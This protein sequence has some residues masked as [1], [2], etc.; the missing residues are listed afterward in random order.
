MKRATWLIACLSVSLLLSSCSNTTNVE[1]SQD[2]QSS[3]IG[4]VVQPTPTC[5]SKEFTDG[6]AWIEGQLK[7]FSE[8]TPD[9]AYSYASD[10]FRSKTSLEAFASVILSQYT[11][12][13][14]IKD[15]QILS[16]DKSG[17]LFSF[18]LNLTDKALN[19]YSMEYLLSFTNNKWG[20]EAASVTLK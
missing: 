5:S 15:Y 2:P 7:A 6:S 4:S 19:S 9:K 13:L 12:L 3:K 1:N 20:V 11:M 17:D 10:N 8:S 18:R 14:N 16:C